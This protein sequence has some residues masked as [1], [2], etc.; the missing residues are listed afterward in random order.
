MV[1]DLAQ[2]HMYVLKLELYSFVKQNSTTYYVLT[3]LPLCVVQQL[4]ILPPFAHHFC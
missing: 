3:A 1:H 2:L 4:T